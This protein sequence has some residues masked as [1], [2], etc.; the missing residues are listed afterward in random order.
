[1]A[2]R[3]GVVPLLAALVVVS[4]SVL[5][6]AVPAA[7]EA[8]PEVGD[9][10]PAATSANAVGDVLD[11]PEASGAEREAGRLL[12]TWTVSLTTS[13]T[14]VW[15]TT[16]ATLTATANQ[17]VGPTPY[18]IRILDR[19][20]ATQ[21]ARCGVGTTC[22]VSVT[23]PTPGVHWY[24]AEINTFDNSSLQALS[25]WQSVNWIQPYVQLQGA[26]TTIPVGSTRT[27]TATSSH[28]VG[29]SP[30]WLQIFDI[31]S[32][33]RLAL[34]GS[35]TSCNA[36]VTQT[37]TTTHEYVAYVAYA[38]TLVPPQGTIGQSARTWLTWSNSGWTV[39][40]TPDFTVD[41][42]VTATTN[43]DVGPTPYW[44]EIFDVGSGQLLRTCGAGTSCTVPVQPGCGGATYAAF[45]SGYGTT[46]LPPNVQ[47]S[48]PSL[49]LY[50]IC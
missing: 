30:Y 37:T 8:K 41:Y 24:Q 49:T 50:A 15:P 46:I 3:R 38:S 16:P 44:I 45:V 2:R 42:R 9:P 13:A 11:K 48:S 35:G 19:T 7:A 4:V 12:A 26:G 31:T 28:D 27:L 6:G 21:V 29:P 1:M 20:S 36:S 10:A 34:C 14:D 40:L 32:G 47:A 25:N 43:A 39:M 5:S 33:T 17:D 18:Y 22:S 23:Q